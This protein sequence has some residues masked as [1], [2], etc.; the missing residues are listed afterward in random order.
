MAGTGL[1]DYEVKWLADGPDPATLKTEIADGGK[2]DKQREDLLDRLIDKNIGG[3]KEEI[4]KAQDV[5]LKQQSS[6]DALNAVWKT[7]L[8][9][10]DGLVT[11]SL[12][13]RASD[14]D[15]TRLAV[16]RDVQTN[17]DTRADVEFDTVADGHRLVEVPPEQLTAMQNAL[18]AI[19]ATQNEMLNS[20][21]EDGNLLFSEKDIMNELW[22]PLVRSGTIPENMVP[23]RFSETAHAF[24]GACEIYNDKLKAFA[25]QSH[26]HEDL[27][28]VL[29]VVKDTGEMF[30]TVAVNAVKISSAMEIASK[31]EQLTK[32]VDENGAKLSDSQ[33]ESM[34]AD[35]SRLQNEVKFAGLA[36]AVTNG[37]LDLGFD[38]AKEKVKAKDDQDWWNFA[39]KAVTLTIS[40]M[41][42]AVD[43][44][45]NEMEGHDRVSNAKTWSKGD[46]PGKKAEG[47]A[48]L[49]KL[50]IVKTVK[51]SVQAGVV[52]I[53]MGGTLRRAYVAQQNGE[54][55]IAV[56]IL[57]E[58]GAQIGDA[59]ALSM[60]AVGNQLGGEAGAELRQ[61]GAGV[62]AAIRA[63]AKGPAI[64]KALSEGNVQGAAVLL[65]AMAVQ[66]GLSAGSEQLFDALHRDVSKDEYADL[67]K[68][69]RLTVEK[70]GS[71]QE[72][73]QNT[74]SADMIDKI[75]KAMEKVSPALLSK[76]EDMAIPELESPEEQALGLKVQ[77][78]VEKKA[79]EKAEAELKKAF[80]DPKAVKE[81]LA[82]FDHQTQYIEEMYAAAFPDDQLP[83]APPDE[84]AKAMDQ[85]DR[86]IAQSQALRQKVAMINAVTSAGASVLAAFV[87][88]GG[89]VVAAQKIALDIY[90]ICK[91]VQLH[92]KW[93]ESMEISFRANSA[94]GPAIE[95]TMKNARIELSQRSVEIILHSLQ[96]GAE[97]G[98]FFDPTGA[99]TITSASLSM[100]DAVQKY[101]YK[102]HKEAAI[103]KGWRAYKKAIDNPGNRKAARKALRLNS[104]LAKCC[105]AYGASIAGDPS[106]MEAM[107]ISGLT[108]SAL[109]DDKDVCNKLVAY[110]QDQLRNDP[111][112]LRVQTEPADWQPGRPKLNPVSWFETKAAA[113]TKANPRLAPASVATPGIDKLMAEIA[114]PKGFDGAE[115]YASVRDTLKAKGSDD[116]AKAL[117]LHKQRKILAEGIAPILRNLKMALEGYRPVEDAAGGAKAHEIMTDITGTLIATVNINLKQV[118]ADIAAK[119]PV[120]P[121]TA[122]PKNK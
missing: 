3:L 91:A 39:E 17:W 110:L 27:L 78:E 112:E 2:R 51:I 83:S 42:Q 21:D 114:G 48:I 19:V 116:Y 29:S 82:D 122:K 23:D 87:P 1:S 30:G 79:Q 97:V 107:R 4:S 111:N 85:I 62:A 11:K 81:M 8:G 60:S 77:R 37:A 7:V 115:S 58:L 75:S 64:L 34:R 80:G 70:T 117:D 45:L 86:A 101:A 71:T 104:T 10:S 32:G 69:E 13:W 52:G 76:I 68:H 74:A 12:K 47:E 49:E 119:P 94:Y 43:P 65:G 33:K 56:K 72:K 28:K 6:S 53:K 24:D 90:A 66:A 105:I 26:G 54:D 59:V 120:P 55:G 93:C 9:Q 20:F 63:S 92:N 95:R 98:K 57:G 38:F 50:K 102:M 84:V 103:I 121:T 44:V 36:Q 118:E 16:H 73:D 41:V 5:V 31:Q 22:T 96:L 35:V 109:Q 113:A 15:I 106:A 14:D 89:A 46:D 108:V 99:T 100:A 88:G 25:E 67:D 61:I 18:D 40:L